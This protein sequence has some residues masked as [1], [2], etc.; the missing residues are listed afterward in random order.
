MKKIIDTLWYALPIQLLV[1]HI[2][3]YQ[4]LLIIWYILF[5]TISGHFLKNFGA[6]TL[7]LAPEYFN[8]VTIFSTAIVGFAF[9][10]FFMSWN[11]T[12]FILH[13][14]LVRFLVTNTNP[15]LKY[16][17]NNSLLPFILIVFYLFESI[18]FEKNQELLTIWELF[19]LSLSFIGGLCFS[20]FI[21]F[22]YF[23]GANR[24]IT[25]SLGNQIKTANEKYKKAN[26]SDE[27]KIENSLLNVKWFLSTQFKI[28]YPRNIKHYDDSFLKK[29]L[30]RHH[31]SAVLAI[32]LS[33]VFLIFIG[34]I[35]DDK[36][37]QIPA[38]A[39]VLIFF[40]VLIA[41]IGAITIFFRTW[42]LLILIV[43]YTGVNFLFSKE[44]IDPR[45]KA[46]GLNYSEKNDRPIYS[47]E[48]I[49][50]LASD[51]NIAIDKAY[52]EQVL[53]NWKAKQKDSLPILYVINTSGGGLRSTTFT[54]NVL[55]K[56]D[57]MMNGKLM[58][59]TAFITGASG[60]MLGATY[61]RELS[62]L[63]AKNDTINLQSKQYIENISNDLLN[64]LFSSFVTR[65]IMGP[66]QK[67]NYNN[68]FYTKDRGYA[69]EEQLNNNTHQILDKQLK[70]YILPE[71]KAEIP[72]MLF[73]SVISQ[74]ARKLIIASHPVR[75]LMKP[76]TN[77]T[78]IAPFESDMIDFN[79]FFKQQNSTDLRL[80]SALRMNATYPYI[81]PSVWLPS[82]PV[83]D[84]M[85]AGIRDNYGTEI[86]LR[87][88]NV[89]KDW[90]IQNTKK[91]VII[92]IRDREKSDWQKSNPNSYFSYVTQP[93]SQLQNNW[94][95][96]QDYYQAGQINY[97]SESFGHHLQTICWQ[98]SPTKENTR[99]RL[100][101]HLTTTEKNEVAMAIKNPD[102]VV[103]FKQLQQQ[104][105]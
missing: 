72:F 44:I 81:L 50:D 77:K 17:I 101:F 80:L 59:Q 26:Q 102:N 34:F 91:V 70:D 75:F 83:I 7:F 82:N 94:F 2:R 43:I 105:K 10:V 57:S 31:F 5:A 16:C 51:K 25:Y 89:F 67:F 49:N 30:T 28:R 66:V 1:L 54:M 48:T 52:Y 18:A 24:T 95:N 85:D 36:F 84:V 15:F 53:N 64:P 32:L 35:S 62:F 13:S 4:L 79:S 22:I 8:Q 97:I 33:F 23:F 20:F 99:V 6:D 69:F 63:K 103:S 90:I 37:F 38:A 29:V 71:R 45:N 27:E 73:S 68:H 41:V 42:T 76:N 40:S 39:S 60:G 93:F 87:F 19:G 104:L 12:T 56:L 65:D 58:H 61:F 96:L 78:Y 88:L 92:Q 9:G 3:K 98:Y 14:N 46:Y 100:S 74:D 47:K 21:S 11:I 86:T 55:A